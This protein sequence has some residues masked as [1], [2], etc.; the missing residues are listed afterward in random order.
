MLLDRDK[1]IRFLFME[2][3]ILGPD[4][5][6][7]ARAA[8]AAQRQGQYEAFH[9]SLMATR[10]IPTSGLIEVVARR[11]NLDWERLNRDMEDQRVY[12]AL[13]KTRL[14]A[15]CL[16]M[17]GT[18]S[19]VIGNTIVTGR[20]NTEELLGIVDLQLSNKQRKDK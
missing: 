7:A 10:S 6:R 5:V 16:G 2:W 11:L 13:E 1:R 19:F 9:D 17:G 15:A 18:P 4:S 8:L 14:L 3:P 12:A 20:V